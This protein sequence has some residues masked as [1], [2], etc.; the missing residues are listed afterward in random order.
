M[1]STLFHI[2]RELGGYPVFGF[3]LLLAL[4]VIIGVIVLV[5]MLRRQGKRFDWFSYLLLVVPVGVVIWGVLPRISDDLGLPIRAYGVMMLLAILAGTGLA[6]WRARRAGLD[7]EVIYSLAFWAFVPG[8]IGARAFY[9]IEYR[10]EQFWP[11]YQQRGAIALLGEVA[12][13]TQG[14]LVVYGSV[15]GGALGFAL[16]VRARRLPVLALSD[17]I[18]PSLVLGLALGRIGCLLNGCCYGHHCEHPWA[19]TFPAG[20]PPFVDQMQH[21]QLS[22]HG[23]RFHAGRGGEVILAEVTP[24]SRAEEAGLREGDRLLSINSTPLGTIDDTPG[25]TLHRA[26]HALLTAH[27]PHLLMEVKAAGSATIDAASRKRADASDRQAASLPSEPRYIH[28]VLPPPG[29]DDW[30]EVRPG[31]LS[32]AGATLE[33]HPTGRGVIV[34]SVRHASVAERWGIPPGARLIAVQGR[35]VRGLEDARR[36][37]AMF[38]REPWIQVRTAE[39]D[40]IRFALD[41]PLPRSLPVHPT[42]LYSSINAALLCLLLLAYSPFKRRHGELTAL[43]LT[44]YPIT[45]YLL[46]VIRTDESP[47]FGTGM[48]ISQNVSLLILLG[49]AVLWWWVLRQPPAKGSGFLEQ[50][51]A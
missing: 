23:L 47:V 49:A 5:V 17:L 46:E 28:W 36:F 10:N 11:V 40:V 43:L 14:G 39:N 6:V 34:R 32:L 48:S 12:N 44:I 13:L 16:F 15:I 50:G 19:V 7:P 24:D 9:V 29:R 20:S 42:Q 21:D 38:Q 3:G 41:R 33:D 31:G 45:R 22:L 27:K 37:L 4:W 2:P 51:G 30:F 26:R 35:P 18:A 1:R 25:D 8:I